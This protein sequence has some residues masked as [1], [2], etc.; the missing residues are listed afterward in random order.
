M[1]HTQSFT[2]K[3]NRVSLPNK[4]TVGCTF[5]ITVATVW[6]A[7]TAQR[8]LKAMEDQLALTRQALLDAQHSSTLAT[9]QTWQAIGNVNWMA[10]TLEGSLHQTREAMET[11][12]KQ[13]KVA[14]GAR[15]NAL[16]RELRPYVSVS[17]M[18]VV[19]SVENGK[20]FSGVATV[21]NSGRTPA[22][23]VQV[24]GDVY[25]SGTPIPDDYPC[26]SPL[27]PKNRV[28][29]SEPSVA[30]IGAG[31]IGG[32][33]SSPGTTMDLQPGGLLSLLATHQLKLYFYGFVSYRDTI[34]SKTIHH[35]TFCGMYGV[36]SK[37][38]TVCE[39]HNNMD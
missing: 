22:I 21:I 3:W 28:P 6:Y 15:E 38:W 25:L 1:S 12:E 23:G 17:D 10:R 29:E 36:E 19:G 37:S 11:S 27:S 8:Q 39:K 31:G 24:C 20:K 13:N 35:T 18:Q 5:L 34:N 4:L 32:R 30:V 16:M 2:A 7:V 9:D 14:L 26:P 33:I